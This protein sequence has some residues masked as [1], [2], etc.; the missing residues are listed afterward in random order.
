[1]LIYQRPQAMAQEP[2]KQKTELAMDFFNPLKNMYVL[3][4]TSNKL[5]VHH[6]SSSS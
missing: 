6:S 2:I 5:V 1:M 3:I 4:P